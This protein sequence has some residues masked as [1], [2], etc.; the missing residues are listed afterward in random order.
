MLTGLAVVV[1][2]AALLVGLAWLFQRNLIYMP[3]GDVLDPAQ[4]GLP[5]AREVTFQT[6]DGVEL[7]GWFVAVERENPGPAVLVF[8]GNAGNRS[9]RAPLAAALAAEGL[10]VL[11]LDYR[12]FGGSGGRP[13][14]TG[15][16]ADARA[17]RAWLAAQE[18]VDPDALIYFGESLGAAVAVS[19]AV[20]HP[21]AA[22]ILRS[23]FTSLADIGRHHYP[24]LPVRLLLEDRFL[25]IDRIG[26][27]R[28]PL[29]IVAG[30]ADRI[31]PADQS[32]RLFDAAPEP[33]R[34]VVIPGVRHNDHELLAGVRLLT[35]IRSFL[36][37]NGLL[38]P[39][40]ALHAE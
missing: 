4:V 13:T 14:E 40:V 25:S 11:L 7:N 32:R 22:L 38:D 36:E 33:K 19:L 37:E 29:L 26:A 1:G 6:E 15:L 35:E 31:V 16:A 30:S 27:L 8:N 34:L 17:A 28:C 18:S 39:V 24:F 9:Y 5:E 3:M 2:G 10:S 23:P 20:E 12:G 21:P